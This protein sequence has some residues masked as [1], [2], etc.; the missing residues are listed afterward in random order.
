MGNF[1]VILLAYA[2]SFVFAYSLES[3]I[4]LA[5]AYSFIF[6]YLFKREKERTYKANKII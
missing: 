5:F 1:Y 6:A 4:L 3:E 2:Y